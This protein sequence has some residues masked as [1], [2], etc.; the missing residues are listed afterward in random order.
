M[1]TAGHYYT[2]RVNR[3]SD[4]GLFLIDEEGEEV[5]LPNRFVSLENKVDDMIRVF[6]YHDSED[7]LV[8]STDQPLATAGQAAFLKVVDKTIHGA[9]LDWGLKAKDLFLPNRNQPSRME[10]GRSYVVYIYTDNVTGR[11]VATARLNGPI[12]NNELSIRER[13][14]VDLIVAQENEFGYRVVVNHRHWGM[15]YRN[16]LF[17]PVAVGDSLK[18][19][20]TRITD[21]RR[22][23]VSLQQQGYDEV[24]KSAGRLLRLLEERGGSLPLTD[25]SSPEEIYAATQMSKKV[26]KRAVGHLMKQGQITIRER[27]ISLIG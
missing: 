2:L 21:D 19:Y 26:F 18:G 10:I 11:V 1:L 3:I 15:L 5:L 12:N 8:A 7:R 23:D 20:V 9:F 16:Q 4:F 25:S 22:V 27:S 14:E 13:E 24:K 6:V 17:Q